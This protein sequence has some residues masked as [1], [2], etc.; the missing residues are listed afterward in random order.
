MAVWLAGCLGRSSRHCKQ[1]WDQAGPRSAQW[2]RTRP[3]RASA[4]TRTPGHRP[5]PPPPAACSWRSR[6][7]RWA[8]RCGPCGRVRPPGRRFARTPPWT[9]LGGSPLRRSEMPPRIGPLRA[10]RT[11]AGRASSGR[12]LPGEG[13]RR[14]NR[15]RLE[16]SLRGDLDFLSF[17]EY[18]RLHRGCQSVSFAKRV[19]TFLSEAKQNGPQ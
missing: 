7:L 1:I 17:D 11:P 15:S 18:R 12:S 19:V 13:I 4:C 9:Y 6:R 10:G 14:Q 3:A 5:C 8:D 16:G 2:M